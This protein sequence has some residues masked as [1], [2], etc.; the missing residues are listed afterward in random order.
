MNCKIIAEKLKAIGLTQDELGAMLGI[1][2]KALEGLLNR[3][4]EA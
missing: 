4:F 3:Y 1:S 2:G